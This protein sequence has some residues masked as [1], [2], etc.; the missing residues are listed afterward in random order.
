MALARICF[1]ATVQKDSE[2]LTDWA[3]LHARAVSQRL[4]GPAAL[5]RQLGAHALLLL[6]CVRLQ[7]A[8]HDHARNARLDD[9]IEELIEQLL[10][11]E[12]YEAEICQGPYGRD[13]DPGEGCEK[14]CALQ[15]VLIGLVIRI[16]ALR[17]S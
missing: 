7:R 3:R 14:V 12:G 16:S 9:E 15:G 13:S 4:D 10:R 1:G 17:N 5:L 11:G 8:V 6:L 2:Y